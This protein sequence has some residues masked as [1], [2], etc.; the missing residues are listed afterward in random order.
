MNR[1][2]TQALMRCPFCGSVVEVV[3]TRNPICMNGSHT[4]EC[5]CEMSEGFII[6]E[7]TERAALSRLTK[8]WNSRM[9]EC[10]FE[11]SGELADLEKKRDKIN[12]KTME[13]YR[14]GSATRSRTTTANAEV[15]NI[16][17]RIEFLRK[18]IKSM[19]TVM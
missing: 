12:R 16:N 1:Y 6:G 9:S 19:T 14:S 5:C 4:I 7:R 3:T 11:L 18:K 13:S 8:R 2:S 10:I 17:E 15:S